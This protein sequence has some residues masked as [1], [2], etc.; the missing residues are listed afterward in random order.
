MGGSISVGGEQI[1]SLVRQFELVPL[2]SERHW[3]EVREEDFRCLSIPIR[4]I[5]SVTPM[6]PNYCSAVW[7]KLCVEYTDSVA[8]SSTWKC[9]LLF[10]AYVLYYASWICTAELRYCTGLLD[11]IG[12]WLWVQVSIQ[13]SL[14]A[15]GPILQY[16][17]PLVV[18]RAIDDSCLVEDKPILPPYSTHV[19]KQCV[20][21]VPT[22][23]PNIQKRPSYTDW[24]GWRESIPSPRMLWI[25]S[26]RSETRISTVVWRSDQWSLTH[27]LWNHAIM[28][29]VCSLGGI[30]GPWAR[31]ID[32]RIDQHTF[33]A[34]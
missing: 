22:Q 13:F 29:N 28:L 3:P 25:S 5:L 26:S 7:H 11:A 6:E 24:G 32:L 30:W 9:Q 2:A 15:D 20:D 19:V 1:I 8:A 12:A 10:S 4:V 31:R 17:A 21:A 34:C 18:M 33:A 14:G 23:D 16:I 27:P